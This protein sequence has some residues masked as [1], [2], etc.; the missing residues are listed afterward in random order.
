MDRHTRHRKRVCAIKDPRIRDQRITAPRFV[1]R[2]L[3][4]PVPCIG[5]DIGDG[6]V[7]EPCQH[8]GALVVVHRVQIAVIVEIMEPR[9]AHAGGRCPL[10]LKSILHKGIVSP[11]DVE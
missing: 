5:G 1:D 7:V 8:P 2:D 4:V 10:P 3:Q 6:R 9:A 11:V